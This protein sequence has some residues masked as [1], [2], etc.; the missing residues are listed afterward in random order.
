MAWAHIRAEK[1]SIA[2]LKL[3]PSEL[4]LDE[5]VFG[6]QQ[7]ALVLDQEAVYYYWAGCLAYAL[8]LRAVPATA[9]GDRWHRAAGLRS[10]R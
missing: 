10:V 1:A 2:C 5:K 4:R 3:P 7:P 6:V 9:P 8:A